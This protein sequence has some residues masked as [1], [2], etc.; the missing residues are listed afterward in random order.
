MAVHATDP[1]APLG[2]H[3]GPPPFRFAPA[4]GTLE[5]PAFS[6]AF[7]L[8]A[9]TIVGGCCLWVARLWIVGALQPGS[10]LVWVGAGL[11]MMLWTLW[12]LLTSRTRLSAEGLHQRWVWDKAMPLREL[13]F[14]KL[15]RVP[16]L[17]WLI[18]PRLYARTL[19]GKFTVFYAAS[20]AMLAEFA[21]LR[22]ELQA[23]RRGGAQV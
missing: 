1:L 2:A 3:F 17:D 7:R 12:H 19:T 14:C 9:G 5:S 10:G 6:P 8:L 11:A 22:D 4:G 13:A 23:F 16:G 20:P 18:A 21:R 15:I